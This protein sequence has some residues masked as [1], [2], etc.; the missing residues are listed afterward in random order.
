MYAY[1][2]E[3]SDKQG[4]PIVQGQD[5]SGLKDYIQRFVWAI[6]PELNGEEDDWIVQQIAK[7]VIKE[8]KMLKEDEWKSMASDSNPALQR[9]N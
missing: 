1:A 9:N 6:F 2:I 3:D 8:M 5:Y 7:D 4:F